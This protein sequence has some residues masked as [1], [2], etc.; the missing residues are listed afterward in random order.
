MTI[1]YRPPTVDEAVAFLL[2]PKTSE[3][4][5]R[6]AIE[7]WRVLCGDTFAQ[8]VEQRVRRERK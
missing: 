2:M 1:Q 6:R 3:L 5:R 7:H 8:T 4:Y